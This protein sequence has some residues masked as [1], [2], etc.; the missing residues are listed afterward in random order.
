L[1][2][3]SPGK[4][5]I[6]SATANAKARVDISRYRRTL[7]RTNTLLERGVDLEWLRGDRLRKV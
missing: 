1:T 7:G 3:A 6:D 2:S 5:E 4:R